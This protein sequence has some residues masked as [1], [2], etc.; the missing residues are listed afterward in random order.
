M[1]LTSLCDV[2]SVI[3]RVTRGPTAY[4]ASTS[5][6]AAG[7]VL[8]GAGIFAVNF[9]KPFPVMLIYNKARSTRFIDKLT[10]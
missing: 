4:A 6:A 3:F 2:G 9:L 8:L 7:F 10:R 1:H 5:G